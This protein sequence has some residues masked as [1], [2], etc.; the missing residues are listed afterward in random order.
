MITSSY[1]L[2]DSDDEIP[3]YSEYMH[4][5]YSEFSDHREYSGEVG[6]PTVREYSESL[7]SFEYQNL[8]KHLKAR[9]YSENSEYSECSKCSRCPCAQCIWTACSDYILGVRIRDACSGRDS[10]TRA[11]KVRHPHQCRHRLRQARAVAATSSRCTRAL[12][13]R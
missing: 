10:R 9:R 6:L 2:S 8:R 3:K 7:E 13:R 12:P 4:A 1:L 5:E 11:W